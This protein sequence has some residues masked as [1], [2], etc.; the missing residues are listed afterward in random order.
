MHIDRGSKMMN[1]RS[2]QSEA[3]KKEKKTR[4]REG[5][6]EGKGDARRKVEGVVEARG[7]VARAHARTRN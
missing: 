4:G 2:W 3:E 7:A 1:P 6:R 5:G